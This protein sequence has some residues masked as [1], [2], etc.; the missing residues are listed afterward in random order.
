MSGVNEPGFQD[1]SSL[2]ATDN[3]ADDFETLDPVSS[4]VYDSQQQN[5][6]PEQ[7]EEISTT[8]AFGSEEPAE[9][10]RYAAGAS[11]AAPS[12]DPLIDWGDENLTQP[13]AAESEPQNSSPLDLDDLGVLGMGATVASSGVQS[14]K[15]PLD[16]YSIPPSE[17]PAVS[18]TVGKESSQETKSVAGNLVDRLYLSN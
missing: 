18:S 5:T 6:I 7:D 4:G 8:N 14:A 16:P 11:E 9:E 17:G 3:Q 12:S 1:F 15:D 10:D 13:S 2:E